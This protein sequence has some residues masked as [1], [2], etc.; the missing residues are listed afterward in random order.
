M[1]QGILI[2]GPTPLF[3]GQLGANKQ[4]VI[5]AFFGVGNNKKFVQRVNEEITKNK[6]NWQFD[7][8]QTESDS[9]LI[10]SQGTDL[11]VILPE[12]AKKFDKGAI[13]AETIIQLSSTDYH[14]NDVSRILTYMKQH[15]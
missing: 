10:T 3:G 11:I 15:A 6:L 4:D 1:K 8:D 14:E 2:Y 7:F 9:A 12:L 13:P 5:S